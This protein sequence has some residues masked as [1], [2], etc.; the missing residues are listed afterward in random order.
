[1]N[2]KGF[3]VS[4]IVYS[5]LILF[6]LLIFGILGIL[7]SRK[8]VLDKMKNEI[9]NELNNEVSNNIYMD[10]S[11]ANYP[12]LTE[13]MIPVIYNENENSWIYADI[14]EKW[15]DYD[16]KMWANAVVLKN[17]ITKTVGQ[18]I[19]EN[20]IALMY[21]WI[22]RFKYTIF[23]VDGISMDEQ[24]IKIEFENNTNTTGT[25][26]CIEAINQ[27][28]ANGNLVS[29][30]CTDTMNGEIINN[31]STYTHPAF[32]FG[33]DEIEGFWVGKFENSTT[34]E[35]CV[36]SATTNNCN[37]LE[38]IITI[39]GNVPSLRYINISNMFYAIRN[40]TKNYG[41]NDADSHMI[42]N[43]EWGAIAYLTNSKYGQGV[44][45]IRINGN[46]NFITGCGSNANGLST[47]TCEYAFGTSSTYLQSTTGNIYGI[48]DMSGG[49]WEKVMGFMYTT[50][51]INEKTGFIDINEIDTKYYDYYSSGNSYTEF[52]RG[53]LGD[54]TKEVINWYSDRSKLVYSNYYWVVR[55]NA[56][57]NGLADVGIFVFDP[58]GNF[59]NVSDNNSSRSV[60]I[61]E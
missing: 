55:S 47:A 36:S 17:G 2:N 25:V 4:G 29:E 34:D 45:E 7:G 60:L 57:Y 26:K 33:E 18:T 28:D 12:R 51:N 1:M 16:E 46:S 43:M 20:D 13:N 58:D 39:K 23:N 8:M 53:K 59:G 31:I 27:T 3:A 56:Y 15:Y 22:P 42:K 50:A 24:E 30:L 9:I 32:T 38:H 21:V 61:K 35:T 10:D 14:Y 49:S 11:G 54:A 19:E 52:S 41:I 44:N 5:V 48:F 6:F 37:K 40:I